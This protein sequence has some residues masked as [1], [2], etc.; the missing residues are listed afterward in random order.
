MK[1]VLIGIGLYLLVIVMFVPVFFGDIAATLSLLGYDL[2][3]RSCWLITIA[4]EGIFVL[5]YLFFKFLR[6]IEELRDEIIDS[7]DLE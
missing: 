4:T 3:T 7:K 5:I 1:K 2:S 6:I